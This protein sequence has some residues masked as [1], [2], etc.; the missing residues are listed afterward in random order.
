MHNTTWISPLAPYSA[1]PER[2]RGG[3][4]IRCRGGHKGHDKEVRIASPNITTEYQGACVH[5]HHHHHESY[6]SLPSVRVDQDR[7]R[8]STLVS[9]SPM[10]LSSVSNISEV[11]SHQSSKV[12]QPHT[13]SKIRLRL[14]ICPN[15]EKGG[16]VLNLSQTIPQSHKRVSHVSS[17]YKRTPQTCGTETPQQQSINKTI[18]LGD[19]DKDLERS[20]SQ[21]GSVLTEVSSAGGYPVRFPD[22][23]GDMIEFVPWKGGIKNSGCRYSVNNIMRNGFLNCAL[24]CD[25][26]GDLVRWRIRCDCQ[27]EFRN[28][29]LPTCDDPLQLILS[30]CSLF[31]W[32]GVQHNIHGFIEAVSSHA[33]SVPPS[34]SGESKVTESVMS[35]ITGDDIIQQPALDSKD[36]SYLRRLQKHEERMKAYWKG[37]K[38][39]TK[40]KSK[41]PPPPISQQTLR[42]LQRGDNEKQKQLERSNTV[43]ADLLFNHI[44][45]R[46]SMQTALNKSVEL[47][48]KTPPHPSLTPVTAITREAAAIGLRGDLRRREVKEQFLRDLMLDDESSGEPMNRSCESSLIDSCQ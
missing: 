19:T 24:H 45:Q 47:R 36:K 26:N 4:C 11:P 9:D 7:V 38:L 6:S 31:D 8:R 27:T 20:S 15:N 33:G 25:Q 43:F 2:L 34:E 14:S 41:E 10:A 21:E 32:C 16:Q 3:M 29:I 30:L 37:K 13:S 48:V 42:A 18:P 39:I 44:E 40:P 23:D 17:S 35:E 1:S 22:D 5:H 12:S 28:V 46:S